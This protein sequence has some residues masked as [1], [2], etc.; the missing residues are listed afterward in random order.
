MTFAALYAILV[1]IAMIGQWVLTLAKKQVPGPEAGPIV[2]R[3]PVEM[4]FHKIAELVTAIALLAGGLGLGEQS[5][6][7]IDGYATVC[8]DK[9]LR[10]LCPEAG[11]AHGRGVCSHTRIR[12][13]QP[14]PGS[15]SIA[16]LSGRCS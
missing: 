9:Q 14:G 16:S 4:L 7:N 15:L 2:G 11:M 1:G 3:G 5:L 8:G 13:H 10:L 6:L 12:T